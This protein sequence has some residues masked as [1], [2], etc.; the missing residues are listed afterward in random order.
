MIKIEAFGGVWH[1]QIIC[2]HIA[3]RVHKVARNKNIEQAVVVVIEKPSGEAAERVGNACL[4]GD[5]G[6]FPAAAGRGAVV[7]K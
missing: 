7:A 6:K 4:F 1:A 3:H 2:D 5:V